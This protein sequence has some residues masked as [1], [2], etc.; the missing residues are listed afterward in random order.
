MV[1][2]PAKPNEGDPAA[3]FLTDTA[4]WS[5]LLDM[6]AAWMNGEFAAQQPKNKKGLGT[7]P[8]ARPEEILLEGRVS[9][10]DELRDATM[11]PDISAQSLVRRKPVL[12]VKDP[13]WH[14]DIDKPFVVNKTLNPT[15]IVGVANQRYVTAPITLVKDTDRYAMIDHTD[16]TKLKTSTSGIFKVIEIWEGDSDIAILDTLEQQRLW[17]YELTEE[18]TQDGTYSAKLLRLDGE[19]YAS[20]AEITFAGLPKIGV[21]MKAEERGYCY[22]TGNE[23]Y[24]IVTGAALMGEP[25]KQNVWDDFT[26]VCENGAICIKGDKKEIHTFTCE[27]E[28]TG[29]PGEKELAFC[30]DC[31]TIWECC[32]FC[33]Y[34]C[35][36]E[37]FSYDSDEC[38]P[39][40]G[41]CIWQWNAGS[42]VWDL[43]SEDCYENGVPGST[44][45]CG[46]Y[47]P[48]S[49]AG[50]IDGEQITVRCDSKPPELCEGDCQYIWNDGQNGGGAGVCYRCTIS[51]ANA[52]EPEWPPSWPDTTLLAHGHVTDDDQSGGQ[53]HTHAFVYKYCGTGDFIADNWLAWWTTSA[54][55]GNNW[56][57]TSETSPCD[58]AVIQAWLDSVLTCAPGLEPWTVEYFTP[59]LDPIPDCPSGVPGEGRWEF[60]GDTCTEDTLVDCECPD[61]PEDFTNFPPNPVHDQIHTE[62]GWCRNDITCTGQ[63]VWR[64]MADGVSE[65]WSLQENECRDSDTGQPSDDCNC[66]TDPS[67]VNFPPPPYEL[68]QLHYEPC[69]ATATPEPEGPCCDQQHT[70]YG[71]HADANTGGGDELNGDQI[72]SAIGG[73]EVTFSM[74]VTDGVGIHLGNAPARLYY[75]MTDATCA[76][77]AAPEDRGRWVLE[78]DFTA[79]G[80]PLASYF[81]QDCKCCLNETGFLSIALGAYGSIDCGTAGGGLLAQA[82]PR[83]LG[84]RL[85]EKVRKFKG[86]K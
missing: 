74:R 77:E 13:V 72:S 54:N 44:D 35:R 6:L 29:S 59:L 20:D 64:W 43:Y 9:Q 50:S 55:P 5:A 33:Q 57:E 8:Q 10:M 23:F 49:G 25:S 56:G 17:R 80:G 83:V 4:M 28:S 66:E 24:A 18:V 53:C 41:D 86:S 76:G 82:A 39:C 65:V 22:H 21:C 63:C 1:K 73:C 45:D 12:S 3:P 52:D 26:A 16:P 31:E 48:P 51:H 32:D 79:F 11:P 36:C 58:P 2:I 15:T 67:L 78:V 61:P 14:T 7:S 40:T 68:G 70:A 38:A 62:P 27:E 19:I 81:N 42:G 46:C 85:K 71:F 60:Y 84:S 47:K 75:D 37:D 30:F 69:I 34:I